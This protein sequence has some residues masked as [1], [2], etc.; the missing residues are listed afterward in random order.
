MQEQVAVVSRRPGRRLTILYP[1]HS[2]HH[3]CSGRCIDPT[4][5]R[6]ICM[7]AATDPFWT[8]NASGGDMYMGGNEMLRARVVLRPQCTIPRRASRPELVLPVSADT[9]TFTIADKGLP[10]R[11][12]A[13]LL[14]RVEPPFAQPCAAVGRGTSPPP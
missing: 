3:P 4:S 10:S 9:H 6:A 8:R 1:L 11:R 14:L 5:P 12:T 13:A 7:Y 2:I